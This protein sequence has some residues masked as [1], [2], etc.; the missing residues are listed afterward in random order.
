[1]RNST[2]AL[3]LAWRRSH[4]PGGPPRLTQ[5]PAAQT[6]CSC[7]LR[8]CLR[9]RESARRDAAHVSMRRP[10]AGYGA[11]ALCLMCRM[12]S[13]MSSSSGSGPLGAD[14]QAAC[15]ARATLSTNKSRGHSSSAPGL[16]SRHRRQPSQQPQRQCLG[17]F[18]GLARAAARALPFSGSPPAAERSRRWK[19]AASRLSTRHAATLARSAAAASVAR[20]GQSRR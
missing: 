11:L 18:Q 20:C 2:S 1:M 14:A 3:L 12:R 16:G 8:P 7:Q 19:Q 17:S 4:A 6:R 13:M 15:V 5:T 10:V 9:A